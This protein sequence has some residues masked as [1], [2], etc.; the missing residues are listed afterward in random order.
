MGQDVSINFRKLP[1]ALF[2]AAVLGVS[3]QFVFSQPMP[4]VPAATVRDNIAATIENIRLLRGVP[5]GTVAC[6]G[7]RSGPRPTI[8]CDVRYVD[9]I[10]VTG[11]E[12]T[13]RDNPAS[14]WAASFRPYM[15]EEDESA[16]LLLID[17]SNPERAESIRRS[18][19]DLAEMFFRLAPKQRVAVAAFDTRLDVLQNF[20]GDGGAVA[21]ALDKIR[22]GNNTTELYRLALEAVQKLGQIDAPRKVLVIASDGKFDDTA[23]RHSQVA[24]EANRL[25]VRIVTIG[26]VEKAADVRDLQSLRRLSADTRGFFFETPGPQ[27]NLSP[28]NRNEF[29]ARL[30]AGVIVEAEALARGVPA[31]LQVSLRHPQGAT[32]LFSVILRAGVA[33]PGNGNDPATPMGGENTFSRVIAWIADD[34]TRA[35]AILAGIAILLG[36]SL[37]SGFA[38]RS[39]RRGAKL[40]EPGPTPEISEDGPPTKAEAVSPVPFAPSPRTI[41]EPATPLAWLEFNSSPGTVPVYK[42][43]VAIGRER[44]NDVVTDAQELTVSRHHAVISL[45]ADG[46]FHIANR[47]ADY[48]ADPNPV[49]VNGVQR[50]SAKIAD[51]DVIKLGTGNYGFLFRL[52]PK[53]GH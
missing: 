35:A 29:L 31:A 9:N 52:A 34:L 33:S 26:Y 13:E 45:S 44:D 11:I 7:N 28:R 32:T 23:Y 51:G 41:I 25:N 53:G 48:R 19:Q 43:R 17:R 14:V 46:S 3:V 20:T 2:A 24:Q 22:P 38:W 50:E 30:H 37:I 49:L 18:T 4:F 42:S 36:G 8:R 27:R 6:R 12:I 10:A 40:P 39:S 47:S 15:H 21:S 16:Y 1:L 5:D